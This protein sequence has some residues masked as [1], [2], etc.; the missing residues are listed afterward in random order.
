MADPQ[1]LSTDP[2]AG[3]PASPAAGGYLSTDPSAG[4]ATFTASNQ[5][6]AQGNA[7]V[8]PTSFWQRANTSLVPH[9]ADA[10]DVIA[11][12]LDAPTLDRSKT[13]AQIRG[14][15]AGATQGA[16]NVLSSFTSPVGLA[17]TAAGLGEDSTIVRAIPALRDLVALPAVK[18]L[19]AA[20]RGLSGAAFAAHGAGQVLTAPTAT[21]K[22]MGVAEAAA[23]AL[24]ATSALPELRSAMGLDQAIPAWRQTLQQR[25]AERT[26]GMQTSDLMKAVPPTSRAPWTSDTLTRARPYLEAE[27][28]TTPIATVTDLRDA[29]DSAITQIEEHVAQAIA[30]N[31]NDYIRS[32]PLNAVQRALSGRARS[33]DFQAGL[34]AVADLGL[35][36]PMT[37]QQADAV[38]LRLNAENKATLQR[39]NYDVA[40]ARETDPAFAAREAASQSLREGIYNQLEARGITGIADLRRDEG[41]VIQIRNAAQRQVFAGEKAVGGTGA[42]SPLRQIAAG[43]VKL[44]ATGVGS[45]VAGP[46]GAVAGAVTGDQIARAIARPN[47]TRDQLVARAF[48]RSTGQS[49]V[50]PAIPDRPSL[51]GYLTA[52][53]TITPPPGDT[54][55]VR[56]VPAQ[57][58]QRAVA[59]LLERGATPLGAGP[60]TSG[61]GSVPA[62][63]IVIR[64]ARTGRFRR[65]YTAE[66]GGGDA[67]Q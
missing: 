57:P 20:V 19:Q 36:K 38:R 42:T 30:A 37:V 4:T 8:D 25:A 1:Y 22:G 39:N 63:G 6:D 24:G 60:D 31:P 49:P 10:A 14:F 64:D 45:A 40:T 7:T 43:T 52:G 50:Y 16:G 29:A 35:E 46:P 54:S 32:N 67:G 34:D 61:G 59:G 53:P 33:S 48:G 5:K 12:Y 55:F 66:A 23:G 44:A 21:E 13:E 18:N 51:S 9:I 41:A 56:G 15:L 65:V 58:A 47:L 27:H 17:L 2:H 28:A 26:A 11:N 62:R 3:Q